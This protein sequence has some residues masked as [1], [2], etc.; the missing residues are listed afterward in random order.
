MRAINRRGALAAIAAG[1][2]GAGFWYLKPVKGLR[3]AEALY[4]R[5]LP[6]P[7]GPMRVYHLGHSL[8]GRDMPAMLEQL[9]GPGR[10]LCRRRSRP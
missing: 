5:P 1:V 7:E 6:Q 4:A 8:V 10:H 3:E 2:A 9:A